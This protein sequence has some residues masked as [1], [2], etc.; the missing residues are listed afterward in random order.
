MYKLI[1]SIF[2]L[3]SIALHAEDGSRLWLRL[4]AG[5]GAR[6]TTPGRTATIDVA[7]REIKAHWRG[8][9]VTLAYNRKKAEDVSA[10]AFSIT[11][12]ARTGVTISSKSDRGLLYG[13]YA[14]LRLQAT[15]RDTG[16]IAMTEA[17]AFERRILN[18]WDNMDGSIERGYAGRSL[19]KWEELPTLSPRYEA[20]ARAN[21]S[22]GINGTVLNNVNANPTVLTADCL[23]K[24][25]ALADAFR[26]YGLR[27]YLSVN[28]NAPKSIGGLTTADP[29]D[30]QV[31]RWWNDK[32]DEIY[33]LVPDF[34]GFLVK[35]NSEGQAGP[36]DYGRTHADGAN[37]LADALAKHGG[38]IMWRAFVYAPSTDD[39]A[40]QA[41][42]EFMPLDGQ[43]RD[44]VI[45]QIKNG[46]VDFQPREAFSPLFGSLRQTQSMIEFQITQEY[47]GHSNHLVFLA[48]L[49]KETLDSETF[50]DGDGSTVANVTNGRAGRTRVTAIAGVA[51]TGDSANW[52]GHHFAQANWYA[53]GRLAWNCN[54][55]AGEI[56]DEWIRQTFT[57]RD[58]F[59]VPVREMMCSSRETCVDYMMPLGLHHAFSF[60]EH[61]GPEP[62]GNLPRGRADWNPVYYHRADT[63]GIGFDRTRRG[64][65]AVSQYNEPLRDELDDVRRCPENLL[66]WFHRVRWDFRMKNGRTLWENLC[67]RY[68]AGLQQARAYQMQWDRLQHMVDEER[69]KAVQRK[70][71]IQTRD[72][73]WWKE[74][75]LLYFQTFSRMPIPFDIE[76]PTNTLEDIKKMNL[77]K[78]T[79]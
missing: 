9:N 77:R 26:P 4:G 65:D 13:A 23:A 68:D 44:N 34:G 7:A 72:A 73:Q 36:Q 76:R 27:V 50:R 12:D 3:L 60:N 10:E 5:S 16:T 24:V 41:Y 6:V 40:K 17:P 79:Y 58:E 63:G 32:A 38:I 30:S 62:W 47:L 64:S 35:A 39:R 54:L 67:Y 57:D 37:M 69:F 45:I 22:I 19:W 61:Y 15:G 66:L 43:F 48:P 28:F 59:L 11:G 56:A 31:K 42:L 2:L 46:P 49:F 25:K 18:H 8:G 29:L 71:M 1:V 52:C 55:S 21:A 20:Y 75:C 51:N 70:L 53:F 33:A 74:A 14:L 78:I